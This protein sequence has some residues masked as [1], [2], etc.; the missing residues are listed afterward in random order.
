MCGCFFCALPS[1]EAIS[2]TPSL[3]LRLCPFAPGALCRSLPWLG[4]LPVLRRRPPFFAPPRCP[5]S[6]PPSVLPRLP[7][8][9]LTTAADLARF[10]VRP[11]LA[12]PHLLPPLSTGP[13]GTPAYADGHFGSFPLTVWP[14]LT[15]AALLFFPHRL[16]HLAF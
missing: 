4:D 5:A 16:L 2:W 3:L 8:T 12:F 15:S 14:P 10:S 6:F 7:L 11:H 13:S 1:L 9:A